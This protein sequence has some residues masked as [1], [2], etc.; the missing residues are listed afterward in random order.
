MSFPSP[1]RIPA[2]E[3]VAEGHWSELRGPSFV[4]VLC[5]EQRVE[6]DGT[7]HSTDVEIAR[8]ALRTEF[9]QQEGFRFFRAGNGDVFSKMLGVSDSLLD[10]VGVREWE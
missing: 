7:L 9:L 2:W 5:R 8:D 4:D 6:G 3:K 1:P 10:F